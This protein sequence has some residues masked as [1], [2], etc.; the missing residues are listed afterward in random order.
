[1][2]QGAL[3][4]STNFYSD[5]ELDRVA[6]L[7]KDPQWLAERLVDPTSRF[8]VVWRSRSLIREHP[9]V[10]PFLIEVETW[11]SFEAL[12][13]ETI[14]LGMRSGIAY[15][16]GDLS[17]LEDS[18]LA[19]LCG[20]AG[21]ADL[22][23]YAPALTGTDAALLAYARGMMHWHRRHQHCG[24]CGERT[25]SRDA[26]HTRICTDSKCATQQFPRT[27]PAVIML[28]TT[29]GRCLLGRQKSWGPG[30]HSTLAG[31]VE[32]GESLEDAVRREVRE[33]TGIE[34]GAV[35]YHS[36]QPWPFPA[37]L[38]VG[39]S[40]EAMTQ[41]IDTNLDELAEAHW[42]SR[43]ELRQAA[44]WRPGVDLSRAGDGELRLPPSDSIARRLI[45]DWVA[46]GDG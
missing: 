34:V 32:P 45:D 33:E 43:D 19:S 42:F 28:V 6:H 12:S 5:P 40:A 46:E 1:M 38:M 18:D 29:E 10:E 2:P 31:F 44:A 24:V 26:G 36:S 30:L 37:S 3:N 15:F 22:R 16:A 23:K 17:G 7:R 9:R 14:L 21:F 4:V 39:F 8:V 20:D 41:A 25:E 27:D 11:R 35:R 13:S